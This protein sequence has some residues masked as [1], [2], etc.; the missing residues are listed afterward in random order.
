MSIDLSSRRM[1][2]TYRAGMPVRSNNVEPKNVP[3]YGLH[4]MGDAEV[5]YLVKVA[6]T[7]VKS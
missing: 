1:R 6:R 7:G 2:E 5:V 4:L 3:M